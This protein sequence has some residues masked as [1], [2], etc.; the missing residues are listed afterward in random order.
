MNA[1]ARA[2][3]RTGLPEA[4]IARRVKVTRACVSLWWNATTRP[5]FGHRL[6]LL[7]AFGIEL[8]AWD[9]VVTSSEA[10]DVKES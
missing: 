6:A 9:Q 4:E 8:A 2:L 7:D 1:G 10:H 5:T 3:R